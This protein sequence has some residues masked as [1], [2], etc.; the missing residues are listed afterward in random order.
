MSRKKKEVAPI[1]LSY[2][3][4]MP[5]VIGRIDSKEKSNWVVIVLFIVLIIF[6]IALPS[7]TT[8]I[9]GEKQITFGP[10]QNE[11]KKPIDNTPV[12]ETIYYDYS[13][14][15]EIPV[16]GLNFK[17]FDIVRKTFSFTIENKNEVK[18]YLVNH[19]LYMELYDNNQ[20]L[21]Q[22]VKLPNENLSKGSS[23]DY[24]FELNVPTAQIAKIVIEEKKVSDY[25]AIQL[26]KES[27]GTYLLVCSKDVETLTYQFDTEGKL[28]YIMDIVNYPSSYENYQMKLMDYRQI[29]S[30]YNGIEGVTSNISEVGSGFTSTTTITLEKIDFE[31]R[32]IK[33]TLNNPAYYGKGTEGKVVYFELSAMNY[34]CS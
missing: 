1:V 12:H 2:Q 31:N 24:Q 11:N 10:N 33:N 25:P 22:R 9:S 23:L 17:Q 26:K 28:Y 4:L 32:S 6:I 34:Q 5:S 15:L 30:K 29:S 21:L 8:Y 7:I 14:T 27:D 3:E 19:V 16:E 18:N 20:T 13:N